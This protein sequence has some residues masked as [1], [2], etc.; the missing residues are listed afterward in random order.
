M[1]YQK[2]LIVYQNTTTPKTIYN[3]FV[4]EAKTQWQAVEFFYHSMH[5]QKIDIDN[6]LILAILTL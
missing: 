1:K 4:V 2:L 6:L 3:T 5:T